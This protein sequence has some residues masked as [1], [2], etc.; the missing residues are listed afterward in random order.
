M[1]E[2]RAPAPSDE[3]YR[4]YTT[5][6]GL[7]FWC[8]IVNYV[9]PVAGRAPAPRSGAL[10]RPFRESDGP[11]VLAL[12]GNPARPGRLTVAEAD[13]LVAGYAYCHLDEAGGQFRSLAVA[14]GNRR[15]GIGWD[16]T[17]DVVAWF[18]A[19]GVA[20]HLRTEVDNLAARRL[21]E[22]AGFQ[23]AGQTRVLRLRLV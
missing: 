9:R 18:E 19:Q 12:G 6:L 7:E 22:R 2:L 5:R 14:P 17:C 21:Y 4:L 1:A 13:G 3:L 23:A 8:E 16:L 20:G 10:V 15:R 11:G